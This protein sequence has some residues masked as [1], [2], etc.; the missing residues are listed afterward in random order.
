GLRMQG[1]GGG[2]WDGGDG[3]G[4]SG[5]YWRCVASVVDGRGREGDGVV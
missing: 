1:S 2:G 3:V 5:G 4:D